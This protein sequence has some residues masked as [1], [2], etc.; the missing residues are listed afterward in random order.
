MKNHLRGVESDSPILCNLFSTC[1]LTLPGETEIEPTFR[2][3]TDDGKVRTVI[4]IPAE[5][6]QVK[7]FQSGETQISVLASGISEQTSDRMSGAVN[8]HDVIDMTAGSGKIV[9]TRRKN[10]RALSSNMEGDFNLAVIR[11]SDI[12]NHSPDDSV[13]EISG[14]IF[15]TGSN[16]LNM[17]RDVF[18]RCH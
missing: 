5:F 18:I 1:H 3:V 17:V 14:H 12:H 16:Q 7:D 4:H 13:A 11:V 6:F 2:C 9:S 15:G 8:R 10:N